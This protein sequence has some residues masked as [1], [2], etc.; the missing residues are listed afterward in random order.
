MTRDD[1]RV[2]FVRSLG[3]APEHMAFLAGDASPRRY[4]RLTDAQAVLMDAAPVDLPDMDALDADADVRQGDNY[5]VAARLAG[6]HPGAF[7]LVA[8]LLH[9]RG[10][11]VPQIRFADPD[12]GFMLLDDLGDDLFSRLLSQDPASEG[13]LYT[14]A[15]HVLAALARSVFPDSDRQQMP[16]WAIRTYDRLAYRAETSLFLDWYRPAQEGARDWNDAEKAAWLA[17]F[18]DAF[19]P[20]AC[21]QRFLVL[22]DVHADNLIWQAGKAGHGRVAFLD[23]QDALFGHPAYDIVSLL[24]D[25]RR[26]VSPALADRLLDG[27]A[28]AAGLADPARFRLEASAVSL[29][30]QLKILGIFHRLARRD[31]KVQY[32]HIF[33]GW[34]RMSAVF[35]T[36]KAGYRSAR[37]C[38]TPCPAIPW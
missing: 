17:A 8:K 27:F 32:L 26:D 18:D 25:A 13:E 31:G 19:A 3:Y 5:M 33:R 20:I 23:F 35:W 37:C 29:Q 1:D 11:A 38:R 28:Q 34:K 24:H 36:R 16:A 30:R 6:L 9:Q 2:A 4:Y 12:R 10:F 7:M 21:E 22:R 14:A 15:T